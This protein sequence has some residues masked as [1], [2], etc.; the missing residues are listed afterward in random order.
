MPA[1]AEGRDARATTM[2]QET[3]LLMLKSHYL[4]HHSAD[5]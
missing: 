3:D 4:R 2:K 5:V 1:V